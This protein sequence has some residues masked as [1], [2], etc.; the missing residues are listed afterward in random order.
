MN[1]SVF[2]REPGVLQGKQCEQSV[3]LVW[4]SEVSGDLDPYV[5]FPCAMGMCKM[6]CESWG[7]YAGLYERT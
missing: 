4:K 5:A 1:Q 2:Q 7:G 6:C 3:S